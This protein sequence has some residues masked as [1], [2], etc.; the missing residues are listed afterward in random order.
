MTDAGLKELAPFT[1]LQA[2]VLGAPG[3]GRGLKELALL[4]GLKILILN[5]EGG[6]G[7]GAQGVSRLKELQWLDLQRCLGVTDAGL[8]ELAP[9][10]RVGGELDL[11][12][13]KVTDAGVAD[14]KKALPDCK[15]CTDPPS[16]P[17]PVPAALGR[18]GADVDRP[19]MG[20]SGESVAG[21]P[22][23][24][25][26]APAS[27]SLSRQFRSSRDGVRW[28]VAGSTS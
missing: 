5:N 1:G 27:S 16:V 25:H 13:T 9:L 17:D 14:L 6:D 21:P 2:L 19:A 8:K 18:T 12:D 26:L 22:L 10:K 11:D 4:K 15:I 3:D 7:R 24:V 28:S 20:P 23:N